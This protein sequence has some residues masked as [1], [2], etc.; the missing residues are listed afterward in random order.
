MFILILF[1]VQDDVKKKRNT[2]GSC[3]CKSGCR[4]KKCSC[5]KDGPFCSAACKCMPSKCA[6]RLNFYWLSFSC[7]SIH[8]WIYYFFWLISSYLFI[9]KSLIGS[10]SHWF[11]GGLFFVLYYWEVNIFGH[12]FV[13]LV[14]CALIRSY[15]CSLVRLLRSVRPSSL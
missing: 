12:W 1:C 8:I 13:E 14:N 2:L 3:G 11:V 15:I 4:N 6:N 7:Q 9:H 10:L 5:K